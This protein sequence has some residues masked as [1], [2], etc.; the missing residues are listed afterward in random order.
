MKHPRAKTITVCLDQ[1]MLGKILNAAVSVATLAVSITGFKDQP[2]TAELRAR[3]K[4]AYDVLADLLSFYTGSPVKAD[5]LCDLNVSICTQVG[6]SELRITHVV[7]ADYRQAYN[8][9]VRA[10]DG[11]NFLLRE[12]SKPVHVVGR[13]KGEDACDK[14]T[15]V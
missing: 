3:L 8:I 6:S 5:D 7:K 15:K 2:T 12:L 13:N 1:N 14:F 10:Q 11:C 4:P 9:R